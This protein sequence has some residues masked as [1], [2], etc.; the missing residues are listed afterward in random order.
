MSKSCRIAVDRT[1]SRCI[2]VNTTSFQRCMP[3]GSS[4]AP[5]HAQRSHY[6]KITSERPRCDMMTS[7]RREYE[8]IWTLC[9]RWVYIYVGTVQ[10]LLVHLQSVKIRK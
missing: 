7:R 3:A 9:A 6:V 4:H 10:L 2:D 1:T 5:V 8:V